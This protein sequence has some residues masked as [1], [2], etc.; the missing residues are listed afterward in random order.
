MRRETMYFT[1]SKGTGPL[2][3]TMLRPYPPSPP[4]VGGQREGNRQEALA[5]K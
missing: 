5:A 1:G 4:A 3:V 2:P